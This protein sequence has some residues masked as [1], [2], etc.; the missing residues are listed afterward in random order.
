MEH[1]ARDRRAGDVGLEVVELEDRGLADQRRS[2]PWIVDTGELDHD[3]VRALLPDL[4]LG[5]AELVD[6]VPH[7]LDRPVDVL[8][9][10]LVALRRHGLEDDL[11]A[12]LQVEAE[13]G[14]LVSRRTWHDQ[15]RDAD[16][17]RDD[18]AEQDEMV[19]PV[20]QRQSGGRV[21]GV[22]SSGS[23]AFGSFS[24]PTTPAIA[25]LATRTSTSSAILRRTSSS[26]TA[27]TIP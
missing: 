20:G 25:R 27:V 9:G 1:A 13:R 8:G 4:G 24:S 12:A 18:A 21:A 6:S 10:Q 3:L 2:R 5:D 22:S 14:L 7:D 11:E 23:G 16:E 15:K 19:T 17:R 26:S